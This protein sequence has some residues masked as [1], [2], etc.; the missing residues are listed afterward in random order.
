MI[1]DYYLHTTR[2]QYGTPSTAITRMS[3][4]LINM[5][6]ALWRGAAYRRFTDVRSSNRNWL[7]DILK[8]TP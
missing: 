3:G 2:V 8:N 5:N 6:A 7:S 1:S 4:E